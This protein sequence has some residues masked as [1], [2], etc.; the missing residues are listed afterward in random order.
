MTVYAAFDGLDGSGKTTTVRTLKTLLDDKGYKVLTYREPGSTVAAE[1][2]REQLRN[3]DIPMS[4]AVETIMVN[5]ARRSLYEQVAVDV[6][7]QKPDFVLFDRS[8]WSTLLYQGM[9]KVKIDMVELGH[10]S[11]MTSFPSGDPSDDELKLSDARA[12]A[13][14]FITELH[15]AAQDPLPLHQFVID[16]PLELR[17][18]RVLRIGK[19]CELDERTFNEDAQRCVGVLNSMY[20]SF[21]VSNATSGVITLQD[22]GDG[23]DYDECIIKLL[24]IKTDNNWSTP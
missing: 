8:L 15:Y 4:S 17:K 16:A 5:A 22:N 2:I 14:Q 13:L 10:I 18:E 7:E 24:K 21:C 3:D 9:L 6:K 19:V 20:S 11:S 23:I 1:A 12:E